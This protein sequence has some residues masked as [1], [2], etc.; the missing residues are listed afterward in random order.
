[1]QKAKCSSIRPALLGNSTQLS[2]NNQHSQLDS[3][4]ACVGEQAICPVDQR[5]GFSGGMA[6]C[7]E[8]FVLL[9]S[10]RAGATAHRILTPESPLTRPCGL[11]FDPSG[12]YLSGMRAWS[13]VQ[14]REAEGLSALHNTITDWPDSGYTRRIAFIDQSSAGC[15]RSPTTV[16]RRQGRGSR[17]RQSILSTLG[18]GSVHPASNH[19][20]AI[21]HRR[22]LHSG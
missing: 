12:N 4:A 11:G 6:G 18:G 17:F 3:A 2:A 1:L 14:M 9:G 7:Q 21:W 10:S 19:Q 22:K 8:A 15:S 5:G 16:L 20:P 13:Q